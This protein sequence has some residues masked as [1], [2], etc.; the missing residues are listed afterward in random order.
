MQVSDE[1]KILRF[2]YRLR[3]PLSFGRVFVAAEQ[4]FCLFQIRLATR[5]L[6]DE[7]LVIGDCLLDF[8]LRGRAR[9]QKR[10]L[11]ST[12]GV[13]A[14]YV[15][16]RGVNSR[17]GGDDLCLCLIDTGERALNPGILKLAL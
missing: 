4:S 5:E 12:L 9:L 14:D 1:L 6:G 2:Q 11:A 3:A 13:R 8:L 17:L 7:A 10:F 16:V 15:C